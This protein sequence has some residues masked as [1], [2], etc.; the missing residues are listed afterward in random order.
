MK[1]DNLKGHQGILRKGVGLHVCE[2]SATISK[3][4][5]VGDRNLDPVE[6]TLLAVRHALVNAAGKQCSKIVINTDVKEIAYRLE[7]ELT[8]DVSKM[9]IADDIYVLKNLFSSVSFNFDS[10]ICKAKCSSLASLAI[11]GESS[12]EWLPPFPHCPSPPKPHPKPP[13]PLASLLSPQAKFGRDHTCKKR[14]IYREGGA[15]DRRPW[16]IWSPAMVEEGQG[17]GK[18]RALMKYSAEMGKAMLIAPLSPNFLLEYF[19]IFFKLRGLAVVSYYPYGCI[20]CTAFICVWCWHHIMD[21]AEKDET[22][23]RCPA[24]R[25]PYN[26]EKIVGMAAKCYSVLYPDYDLH[27]NA[28]RLVSEMNVEKKLKSQKGKSKTL[29]GRKQLGSVRVIQRNLVYVVGL[30][31]NLSDEDLLQRKDHF[32]QYGKVL[33]IISEVVSSEGFHAYLHECSCGWLRCL[34]SVQTF[35]ERNQSLRYITYSKEEE[36]VRCIQSV[37]GFVL[38]GKPLRAC[39]GTT[40]YCHAWLRNVPCGNP[41]CLYLHEVG[42]Q[43]DSYTKDEIVSAYTRSRVQQIT[44]SSNGMQRRSGNV[45]PPPADEY[46]DNSSSSSGKPITKT[47]N[48]DQNSAINTR[49]SPPNS[50]SGRSAA[51]PAGASWGTRPSS[52]NQPLPMRYLKLDTCDGPA[53]FSKAVA[54][55]NARITVSD[56]S[57]ASANL[58]DL[59]LSRQPHSPSTTKP[60]YNTSDVVDSSVLSSEPALDKGS[61]DDRDGN[62]ENVCSNILSMSLHEN[63]QLQNGYVE[64]IREPLIRQ[65]SEKAA[66]TTEEVGIGI[67]QSDFRLGISTQVRQVDSREM[68]DDLL[69]FDNQRINDPEIATNRMPSHPLN[70]SK[71]SNIHYPELNN[72][73]IMGIDFDRHAVARNNNVMVSTSNF[74]SRHPENILN[75]PEGNDAEYPNMFPSK[76]RMSLHQR[77]EVGS[78]AVDIGESSIISDILSMDFDPWDESLT[79]PQS[80][81]KLLGDTDKRQGSFGAPGSWK[82]QNSNQSR[83]SFARE[84]EPMSHVS[85]SGQS[86]EYY[87]QAFRQR[88]FGHDFSSRNSLYLERS[89]NRNGLPFLSGTEPDIFASSHSHISSNKLPVSRSQI[90]APP[91]FSVPNRA[92]PPGFNSHERTEQILESVSGNHMIDASSFLRNQYQPPSSSN[93]NFSNGEI[94]FMDPAIL[95]VG[96]GINNPGLDMRSNF[97]PQLSTYEDPRFQSFLQRSLPPHENQRYT[98]FGDSFSTPGDAYGIPSRIMDQTLSNSLSPFS[99]FSVPQSRNGITSNRQWDALGEAQSGNS[100]GMAEMRRTEQLG[101][102]KFYG[103]YEDSKIQG[104]VQT[105]YTMEHMGFNFKTRTLLGSL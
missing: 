66:D 35:H 32:G 44:G 68:E 70:L 94:E 65:T 46:C 53:A 97:P 77:Y 56:S 38:D 45:L 101:F 10:S 20:D 75:R 52:N 15:G 81:S 29:E 13:P 71:H 28:N 5:A 31:L 27:D 105:I 2:V 59:P 72:A 76:E 25:T 14:S 69:S 79:S 64:H 30:P 90:S 92:A 43:E 85:D 89:V 8:F 83:F 93:N 6:V 26:K 19:V 49:V 23:G 80:L 91:G 41:D 73:G 74:S 39:F 84:G 88:P 34:I 78:A 51:L 12:N 47:V 17:G 104:L 86:A 58:A 98:N 24:C 67:V 55:T 95:A 57:V 60:P 61:S 103:S 37:H 40:K 22:E 33:K 48:T 36:A 100:L 54:S 9:T 96:R 7:R 1:D 42:S 82:T 16:N 99:K 87:E 21:M 18:T 50:S 102:N 3:K 62:M 4:G 63:Q 11:E